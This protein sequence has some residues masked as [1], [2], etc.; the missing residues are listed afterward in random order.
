MHWISLLIPGQ[1]T[2]LRAHNWLLVI[3][4]CP[5]CICCS[6]SLLRTDPLI[7]FPCI[8]KKGDPIRGFIYLADDFKVFQAFQLSLHMRSHCYWALLWGV[9]DWPCVGFECD[10]VLPCEASNSFKAVW[11]LSLKVCCVL[12]EWKL[13]L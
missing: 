10:M 11:K 7:W 1:Y 5:S 3:P 12:N 4:W 13:L 8:G 9:Y 6:I 2:Q